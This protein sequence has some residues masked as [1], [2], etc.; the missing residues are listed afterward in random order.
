MSMDMD[1]HDAVHAGAIPEG[2]AQTSSADQVRQ[3]G[4]DNLADPVAQMIGAAGMDVDLDTQNDPVARQQGLAHASAV[5]QFDADLDVP[6]P[7]AP[8]RNGP[9]KWSGR[10][11]STLAPLPIRPSLASLPRID[12]DEDEH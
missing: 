4:V 3:F 1:T 8:N 2:L 5:H 6:Q 11:V 9:A 10:K 7:L 12:K